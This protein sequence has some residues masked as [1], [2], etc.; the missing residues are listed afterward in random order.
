MPVNDIS[1]FTV[2]MNAI[3]EEDSEGC[4]LKIIVLFVKRK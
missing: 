3:N 1:L 2:I 4:F